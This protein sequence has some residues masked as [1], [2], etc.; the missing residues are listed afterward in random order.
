MAW[1][2]H[3]AK[4]TWVGATVLVAL[5][6][7]T[8]VIGLLT[9]MGIATFGWFAYQPLADATFV[10]GGSAVVLSRVTVAGWVIFAV[11]LVTLAFL[12]GRAAGRKSPE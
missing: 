3:L 4:L 2:N 7:I 10:P 5:G 11:G 12:A 6:V 9:P 1:R 8:I